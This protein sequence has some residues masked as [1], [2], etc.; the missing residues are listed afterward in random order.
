MIKLC[1]FDMD[2]L[3]IDSERY[4]WT[5]SMARAAKEQ[6]KIMTDEFHRS[7]MGANFKTVS[8]RLVEEYG[9]DFDPDLFF[10]RTFELNGEIIKQGIPLMKGARQLLDFLHEQNI[11]T[12]IGTTTA[13]YLTTSL[14]EADNLLDDFDGI[15]CGNEIKNGKPA[16]DIYLACFNKFEGID[17]SEVL[18]F[19][20]GQAG[21]M[22][23]LAAGMRLVL[24]PDLAKLDDDVRNRA[25]KIIDNL[26]EIIDTIKEEN[27]ATFSV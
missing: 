7:F 19:E 18:V 23:A 14:L 4:L 16:P 13:R 8:E 25:Y 20:D 2:G 26:A 21:A 27:E 6:G 10:K 24:V 15:V 5:V 22:A 3:L 11:K 12:C 17:L 9:D 1:I